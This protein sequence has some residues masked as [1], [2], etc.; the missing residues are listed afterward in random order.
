MQEKKKDT[1]EEKLLSSNPSFNY[2]EELKRKIVQEME[3]ARE[4]QEKKKKKDSFIIETDISKLSN[5]EKFD[6]YSIYKIFNRIQKTETFVNGEQ[7]R[8]LMKNTDSYVVM[9]DHRR[10]DA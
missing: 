10:I 2:E 3:E 7:A 8:N 6:R 1:V 5:D 4:L 9:F